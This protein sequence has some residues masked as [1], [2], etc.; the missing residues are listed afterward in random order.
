MRTERAV[1]SQ[2]PQI[3]TLSTGVL[4][5]T[6]QVASEAVFAS[7]GREQHKDQGSLIPAI[8]IRLEL[9]CGTVTTSLRHELSAPDGMVEMQSQKQH[10]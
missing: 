10:D 4:K 7:I 1:S 6:T 3:E 8:G 5:N 9:H 2:A